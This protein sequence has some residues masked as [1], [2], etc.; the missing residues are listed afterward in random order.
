[1]EY[2]AKLKEEYE[3]QEEISKQ[4]IETQKK[5]SETYDKFINEGEK[6]QKL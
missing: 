4:L 3:R 5:R 6:L 1:M 2:K